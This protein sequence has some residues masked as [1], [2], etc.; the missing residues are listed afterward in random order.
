MTSSALMYP[1]QVSEIPPQKMGPN[2]PY[3]TT[4]DAPRTP[5]R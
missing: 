2:G 4:W 3:F 1:P 5:S